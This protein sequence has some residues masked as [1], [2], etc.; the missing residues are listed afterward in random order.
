MLPY[1][2]L[3]INLVSDNLVSDLVMG[4]GKIHVVTSSGL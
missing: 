1:D 3:V 4:L 2:N